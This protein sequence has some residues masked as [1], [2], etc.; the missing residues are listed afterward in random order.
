ML[1]KTSLAFIYSGLNY[2]P[3][4]YFNQTRWV[5]TPLIAYSLVG[6]YFHFLT[7]YIGQELHT[8]TALEPLTYWLYAM[9][10]ICFS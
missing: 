2:V 6:H 7:L 4:A 3:C 8:Q 9:K 5:K 1:Q 10:R